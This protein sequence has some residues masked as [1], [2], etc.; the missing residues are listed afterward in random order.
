MYRIISVDLDGTLL[1]PKNQ[2]T[3]YTKEII[4][5]LIER[6]FYFI[7]ASGRH[8]IDVIKI[9]DILEINA[10]MITANG[11]KIYNLDGELIFNNNL[12]ADI[13]SK[14]CNIKYLDQD[15]ITQIFTD[16]QWYIN[17]N[18]IDNK[19]CPS[20][21]SLKYKYFNLHSL[22]YNDII[23]IFFTSKNLNKLHYIEKKIINNW[24]DKVNVSFSIPSCLEVVSKKSSKGYGLKVISNLLGISLDRFIAFGDGMND[25]D[26][27]R[28]SGKSYIMKNADSRLK[29]Q[30]PHIEII[31]DNNDGVA[32]FLDKKFIKNS[33][34]IIER[35]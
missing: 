22:N 23:K 17:N 16:D 6:G 1:S 5:L 20:L 13:A 8:C 28:I 14:I 2:I 35:H 15:V 32:K 9:R 7:L 27:L 34:N 4:K 29:D 30:L 21:S 18:K 33:K 19:F 10:F 25:E 12:D 11:A 31:G 26:M 24:A 3:E